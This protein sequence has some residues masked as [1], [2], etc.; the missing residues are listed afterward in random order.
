VNAFGAQ[1][2]GYR[3]KQWKLRL[4]QD[5]ARLRRVLQ[6]Q[7]CL[8]FGITIFRNPAVRFRP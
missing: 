4:I 3:G 6:L 2:P 5:P 1:H 7:D 8:P